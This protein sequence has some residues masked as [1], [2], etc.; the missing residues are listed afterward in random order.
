MVSRET[1]PRDDE[2][3]YPLWKK[4][5]IRNVVSIAIGYIFPTGAA[6]GVVVFNRC[7]TLG[8]G[9]IK[10]TCGQDIVTYQTVRAP[11]TAGFTDANLG[12]EIHQIGMLI[13]GDLFAQKAGVFE[14]LFAP[15]NFS[16]GQFGWIG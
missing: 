9:I 4:R 8:D 16:S 10:F 14:C 1:A 12:A 3:G 15:F 6:A 5:S 2:I 7:A 13:A 11:H